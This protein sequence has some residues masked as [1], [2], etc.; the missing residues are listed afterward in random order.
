MMLIL[1]KMKNRIINSFKKFLILMNT[2]FATK[3][4]SKPIINSF[5]P[6]SAKAGYHL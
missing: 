2:F 5:S 6:L 1:F 3:L 4:V